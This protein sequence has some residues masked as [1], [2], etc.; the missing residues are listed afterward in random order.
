MSEVL[1][2]NASY[3]KLHRVSW[4]DAIMLVIKHKAVIDEA[5]PDKYIRYANGQFPWP[6]VLRLINYVKVPVSY[7]EATW[8]RRGV[9]E[10]DNYTCAYCG[11]RGDTIDHLDPQSRFPALAKDWMNTV[12]ACYPCNH[13]KGN[14]T[15]KES[16][17]VLLYEPTVPH[18]FKRLRGSKR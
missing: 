7:G 11:K 18:S 15:L 4:Q 3:E 14:R 6:K 5:I 1:V 8:T 17:F 10:R 9:L 12:A 13:K 2:L 16:G